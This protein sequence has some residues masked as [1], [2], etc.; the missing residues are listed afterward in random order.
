MIRGSGCLVLT[1]YC[2]RIKRVGESFS[3]AKIPVLSFQPLSS[4]KAAFCK[5]IL[6]AGKN[7]HRKGEAEASIS[8]VGQKKVAVISVSLIM[9][10][11]LFLVACRGKAAKS[12]SASRTYVNRN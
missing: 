12:C 4:D 6:A 3:S 10:W 1:A 11:Y 5:Q 2:P 9:M 7:C 8:P